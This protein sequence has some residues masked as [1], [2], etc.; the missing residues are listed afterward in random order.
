M[1]HL[2]DCPTRQQI[3]VNEYPSSNRERVLDL[4]TT[5]NLLPVAEFPNIQDSD[6]LLPLAT[7][8]P[9]VST[10]KR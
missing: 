4:R 3:S 5:T 8:M 10:N 1:L 2:V 6:G 7:P 9:S